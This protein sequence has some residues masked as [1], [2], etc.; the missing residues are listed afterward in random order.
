MRKLVTALS[1]A[2]GD[3]LPTEFRLFH[4]GKNATTKGPF[5]F[6]DDGAES[7]MQ[8]FRAHGV[9]GMIDLEHLSLDPESKSY[10]PDARG[11]YQLEVRPGPELWAVNVRWTPDGARRLKEK[12]QRY[13]SPTFVDDEE[14]RVLQIFNVALTALPATHETPA[15]VA[16]TSRGK[17]DPK[18]L[19]QLADRLSIRFRKLADEVSDAGAESKGKAATVVDKMTAAKA[20]MD[21]LEKAF[22]GGDVDA[23]F[24]A[25]DAATA[26]VD[27]FTAACSAMSGAAASAPPADA[28]PAATSETQDSCAAPTQ[29]MTAR[30]LA[31]LNQL[32]ADRDARRAAEKLAAERAAVERQA[33]EILKRREL[34]AGMVK[35]GRLTPGAAWADTEATTPKSIFATMPIADLEQLSRELG[36]S[37]QFQ[38]SNIRPPATAG[39]DGHESEITEFEAKRVE[40]AARKM[41]DDKI[42]GARPVEE[43]LERYRSHK[44]QGVRGAKLKNPGNVASLARGIEPKHVLLGVRSGMVSLANPVQPIQEFG[45]SSQRA[46][47]EF[48]LNYNT[49]L[50]AMPQSW[51]EEI[52]DMLPGGSLKETYPL[53][54]SATKYAEVSSQGA[55]AG[56][57]K[58]VDIT[59]SKRQ[60]AAAEQVEL[61]RLMKGDFAYILS[62]GQA[63]Q[64]MA[65]ARV[66]LRNQLVKALLEGATSGYWGQTQD[67][68]TGIDG[69]PFFS[70]S[71]KVNPFDP[72]MK[73]RNSATWGNY[74]A[75][76]TPLNA[77]NLTAEKANA[78]N[79]PG[80]D[81]NE[82]GFEFDAIMYPSVLA[83][84]V[85]NLITVQDII[86]DASTSKNG[87][88]NVFGSMRNPHYQS[89]LT[90]TRAPELTGSAVTA[91]YYL[92]SRAAISQG[93]FPWVI[94]EDSAEEI[95]TWDE[96]SDFYKSSGMIKLQSNIMLNAVLLYPHAIRLVKGS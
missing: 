76:A 80:P 94:S 16:A 2:I 35:C 44:D 17:M 30:E 42:P 22:K 75:S 83:E 91:N 50:A 3:E 71:H 7:V 58:N 47:E 48:R 53:N 45:A 26:A 27:E 6:D 37:A 15:L 72:T 78:F 36:A 31:E 64:R 69:Q 28:P 95:R 55:A 25:I 29:T 23:I 21:A 74:Q 61:L 34:V 63:A 43:V 66:F 41:L 10:D 32:R 9:D 33:Q 56:S 62:W 70:A 85:K 13:I 65:R 59:V 12:T 92:L 19:K 86:L 81:G 73:F 49:S 11:W 67:Q 93:L 4:A 24:A 90:M 84:T 57:G 79:I 46:L 82:L 51:A 5:I 52:G 87:V 40:L 77:T 1:I 18:K 54:F 88:S 60:F 8:A 89:G 14:R 38:T 20:A 68:A 39:S 96:S